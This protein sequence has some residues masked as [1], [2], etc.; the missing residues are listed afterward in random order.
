MTYNSKDLKEMSSA[1]RA[2]ALNTLRLAHSGHIGIVLGAADVI[3]TV[4]AN[5]LRRGRDRFVLSA[6][7]G[8]AL[9][10][11]VLKLSGYEIGDMEY[12]RQLDLFFAN[13]HPFIAFGRKMYHIFKYTLHGEIFKKIGRKL[14]K[15]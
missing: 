8:S 7:H 3:T 1:V 9:L 6:G 14:K 4:Y 13:G 11:S 10:Y 2:L 15:H 5:F 12:F